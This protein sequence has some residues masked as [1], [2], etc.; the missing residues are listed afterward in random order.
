MTDEHTL[1][2]RPHARAYALLLLTMLFWSMNAVL[3]RI[4]VGQVSPMLLVSLR[5]LGSVLLILIFARHHV[6]R[7]W[8]VLR[9]HLLL[10]GAMGALGFAA[11]NALFYTAAHYTTAVNIGIIQGA[12]PVFVLIGAFAAYRTPVHGWQLAGVVL[13]ISGVVIVA[14]GGSLERLLALSINKGDLLLIIA[15]MLYAGYAVGLQ[16]RPAVSSLSLFTILA[17]SAFLTSLPLVA[18]EYALGDLQWPTLTGWLVVGLITVFPSFLAQILFM[19]GVALIGPGR[20]A[21][22]GNLVPVF[23]PILAVLI[24]GESFK[25]YHALALALVL[26]GIWLAER[27]KR[28]RPSV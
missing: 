18:A 14:S 16:R 8:P 7:D 4:A 6:F 5:W 3:S 15:T 1:N 17:A 27:V 19:N 11:F 13:T 12:M 24:L 20:A 9:R 10:F 28:T 22:F 2:E 23:A 21:I 25:S 26:S